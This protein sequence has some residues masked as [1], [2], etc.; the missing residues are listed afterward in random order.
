MTA[1]GMAVTAW[2]ALG[3]AATDDLTSA[4]AS[5][6]AQ[7]SRAAAEALAELGAEGRERVWSG[8]AA[9][10][11]G[12]RRA[13]ARWVLERSEGASVSSAVEHLTDGDAEVRVLLVRFLGRVA[14][15]AA[16]SA[17][18]ARALAQGGIAE[19]SA[20]V[21][22]EILAAAGALGG[23]WAVAAL[24]AL[25]DGWP[26]PERGEAAAELARVGPGSRAV[27]ERVRAGFALP[28]SA[29]GPT[30]ARTPDDVL[31]ALLEAYARGLA[32]RSD[33]GELAAERAPLLLALAHP[34]PPVRAAAAR[35]VDTL[36]SRLRELD[37]VERAE[38]LLAHLAEEGLDAREALL[39]RAVHSLRHGLDGSGALAAARDLG[40]ARLAEPVLAARR[41]RWL[42]AYLEGV[43]HLAADRGEDAEEAFARGAEL[44]DGLLAERFDLAG[45]AGL[46]A[47]HEL[48]HE[49]ALLEFVR[50]LAGLARGRGATDPSSLERARLAHRLVLEAQVLAAAS[51]EPEV[52]SLDGLFEGGLSPYRL[53]FARAPHPAWPVSR[54][55][56]VQAEFGRLL[57]A[58]APFELPGFE[59]PAGLSREI[60]DPLA[61]P[62]RSELL[63]GLRSARLTNTLAQLRRVQFELESAL[64]SGEGEQVELLEREARLARAVRAQRR[65]ALTP[66]AEALAELRTPSWF[67]LRLAGDLSE[68]GRTRECREV[69]ERILAAL[70]ADGLAQRYAW[71]IELAA[72][73]RITLGSS[74]SSDDEGVLAEEEL[75]R[76]VA[77]LEGLERLLTEQGGLRSAQAVRAARCDALVS[78]AVNAN[79]KLVDPERALGYFE[80]AYA[81]RSDDFM[82]VLLACYRARSGRADEARA[83]LAEVPHA[84]RLFYNLACTYALLGQTGRALEYLERELEQNHQSPG[85]RRRQREWARTDPD[86]VS[87][88][89]DP[90]FARLVGAADSVEDR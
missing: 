4:L 3:L 35:A 58:V 41:W 55:L 74:W 45:R 85:A 77:H 56:A 13:R 76:A 31:A 78:L 90:R 9:A 28:A 51:D 39:R 27:V 63:G 24:A 70:E 5:H 21:R 26:A 6:D 50:A 19:S 15:D 75:L 18:R 20:R 49:R 80:R 7:R 42:A 87:L 66:L 30:A 67:A 86:L 14:T 32:E 22:S 57:A 1:A 71:G 88:R 59:P 33:G 34:A 64:A 62:R 65:T 36:I 16:G 8:F 53:L 29:A 48:L 79:V 11:L 68:E 72:Q 2:L 73:A 54:C 17:V 52:R 47:Q 37:H 81:L 82:D 44:L 69:C 10:P 46:S 40:R 83:V 25:V 61:D 60:A 43:A 23:E 12:E 89:E 38:R 84:P